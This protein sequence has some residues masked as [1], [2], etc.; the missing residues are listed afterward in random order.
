LLKSNPQSGR[1]GGDLHVI[2]GIVPPITKKVRKGCRFAPRIQ[3]IGAEAHEEY[4]SMHELGQNQFV[5][6]T[7]HETF[8][9][10]GE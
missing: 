8:Y 1:E 5:R 4:P 10:E 9:F 6:C 2:E 7:C 3:W